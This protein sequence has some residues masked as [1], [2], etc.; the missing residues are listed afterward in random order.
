MI[1]I[2]N[3][4]KTAKQSNKE[5]IYLI[6]NVTKSLTSISDLTGKVVILPTLEIKSDAVQTRKQELFEIRTRVGDAPKVA[7]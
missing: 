6:S 1:V 4:T 5:S 3:L 7:Y 2:L